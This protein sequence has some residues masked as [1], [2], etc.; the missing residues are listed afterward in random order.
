MILAIS[1]SGRKN[2]MIHQAV[3]AIAAKTGLDYEVLSLSGK[4]ISGCLGCT[5][6]AADNKCVLKDD[7]IEIGE[8]MAAADAIIFGAPN[9]YGMINALGHACWER[10]FCFRHRNTFTL[11]D[12]IAVSVSTVRSP[13]ASDPVKHAIQYFMNSNKMN[14]VAHVTV[15][16]HDQCY[17]CGFGH[18]CEAGNV[19]RKFGILPCISPEQMPLEFD[20]QAETSKQIDDA[21]QAIIKLL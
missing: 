9:Y 17:T 8:K 16:G 10:T 18:D 5:L 4:R 20:Q 12:K 11:K 2:R 6:C 13:A 15:E 21:S 19:F 1:A 3:E 14:I 7:W